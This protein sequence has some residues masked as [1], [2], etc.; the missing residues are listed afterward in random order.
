MGKFRQ[1][2]TQLSARNTPIFSFPNVIKIEGVFLF[3]IPHHTIVAGYYGF[4]LVVRESVV[5]PSVRP[6]FLSG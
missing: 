4:T 5:R 1:F 2:L 3:M 6:F